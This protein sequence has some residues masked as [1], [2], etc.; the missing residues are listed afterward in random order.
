VNSE[1]KIDR[2]HQ[3]GEPAIN[4]PMVITI[5][6]VLVIGIHFAVGFVD[7]Q[8]FFTI[9]TGAAFIPGAYLLDEVMLPFPMARFWSPVTYFF[10]HADWTHVLVNMTMLAAFG[11][12]TAR[13]FG[14][15]KFL[16]F[17]ALATVASALVHAAF[18]WASLIPVIGA[19]GAVSACMGAAV[20]FGFS[21]NQS[22][23]YRK[24]ALS[25][26]GSLTNRST[27]FFVIIWFGINWLFGSVGVS[28][29]GEEVNIAWEAHM[30]GFL[31]G[32]V[33]FRFFDKNQD[34]KM[35]ET[36]EAK[37]D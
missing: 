27:M 25:L 15:V 9:L 35:Q 29:T 5:L 23:A 1:D 32:L 30:G 37:V 7:E 10:L 28:L 20:R 13:R 24:P 26:I 16:V 12:A 36:Y 17:L 21:P 22:E 33:A 2:V 6:I 4:L 18:Y 11:G 8:S 34:Q 31:F 3:S 14:S 19:S